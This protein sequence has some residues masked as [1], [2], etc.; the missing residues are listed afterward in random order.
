MNRK[1][2]AR[3]SCLVAMALCSA[4]L[5][6]AVPLKI[7]DV[8]APAI[9]CIFNPACTVVVSDSTAPI[10]LAGAA[11]SGFLQSRTVKSTSASTAAGRY[12]YEYRVDLRQAYGIT[13]IP[14][15]KSLSVTF[16]APSTLDYNTNGIADEQVYVVTSGGLGSVKPTSADRSAGVITFHFGTSVCA[17]SSPGKGESTYFFGLAAWGS[18]KAITAT[19]KDLSDSAYSLAARAPQ[20]LFLPRPR[21]LPSP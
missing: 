16:G 13:S 11:G 1:T 6:E 9:N 3:D 2:I 7:V 14:C 8:S 17:G 18:P 5:T 19:L 20:G 10:A 15:V 4:G 21:L 12:S